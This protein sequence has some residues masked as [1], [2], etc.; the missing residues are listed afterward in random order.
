MNQ[1]EERYR[2]V[3]RVLP[4]SHRAAWEEDMVAAFL[5][6]A[7]TGDPEHDEYIADFGRPDWSEVASVLAL[8]VRLRLARVGSP[9]W[10]AAIRWAVLTALLAS[11]VVSTG[12]L[13]IQ[14]WA[15][16]SLT[17]LPAAPPGW[18]LGQQHS[19]WSAASM[20]VGSAW[21]LPYLALVLG[22]RRAAQ[23]LA[24]LATAAAL[25]PTLTTILTT[26][27]D[28]PWRVY[29]WV[30]LLVGL[31]LVAAMSAFTDEAPPLAA[32]PWLMA[33]AIGTVAAVPVLLGVEQASRY[34]T[35]YAL[36]PVGLSCALLV[37]A[38]CGHLLRQAVAPNPAGDAWARAL[39]LLASGALA[40]RLLTLPDLLGQPTSAS[41][42]AIA[43]AEASAV[44]VVG[45]LLLRSST[46]AGAAA[47]YG[48][49][50]ALGPG[51]EPDSHLD[52]DVVRRPP[53]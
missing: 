20:V 39:L 6:S 11:A 51:S 34:G 53:R 2:R 30:H 26:T 7:L 50:S 38:A 45:L 42:V 18:T 21:A 40:Q 33:L 14:A 35:E 12:G 1:L 27:G 3:L 25:T 23:A 43:L 13:A 4:A 28:A 37:L 47:A 10:P 29:P 36:D 48:E 19:T 8:A 16:G 15:A 44:A 17:W 52:G 9:P 22:N 41:Q 49:R 46:A 5:E 32:T 31:L 24:L